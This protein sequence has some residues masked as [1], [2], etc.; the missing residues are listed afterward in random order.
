MKYLNKH[1]RKNQ[2]DYYYYTYFLKY[3]SLEYYLSIFNMKDV[4]SIPYAFLNNSKLLHLKKNNIIKRFG[5]PVFKE[6]S[7]IDK[8]HFILFYNIK[9]SKYNILKSFHFLNN[10]LFFINVTFQ[11][12]KDSDKT[13]IINTI[14]NIYDINSDKFSSI[15]IIDSEKN[16]LFIEDIFELSINYL[17]PNIGQ[18]NNKCEEMNERALRI[19]KKED[20][21][22]LH[23]FDKII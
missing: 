12:L 3:Q 5:K 2:N 8:S 10:E 7:E 17:L 1:I 11:Q 20:Q 22:L 14:K 18:L 13:K 15:K 9:F 6:R 16:I 21:F 23:L 4:L 19:E